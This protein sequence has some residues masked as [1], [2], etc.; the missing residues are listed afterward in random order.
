MIQQEPTES[1]SIQQLKDLRKL[2]GLTTK[3]AAEYAGVSEA[4][5]VKMESGSIKMPGK[6]WD[7]INVKTQSLPKKSIQKQVVDASNYELKDI[8]KNSKSWFNSEAKRLASV[9]AGK[10]TST[11]VSHPVPG[12]LYMYY[13]DAKHKDT[14]PYWDKFPLVFPFRMMP[15][16][17]IGINLHYLHY[18]QRILLLDALQEIAKSPRKTTSAKLTISYDILRTVAKGKHF[19]K[20]I[21]RYL[22]DHFKT[23][24]KKIHSDN[25]VMASLLPNEM[26]VGE[27]KEY[28]WKQ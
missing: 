16:G 4:A 17:F 13:Y 20:C 19:E 25:W 23:P 1:P 27:T 6:I 10:L 21:H 24:I 7:K 2:H 15:D 14:L 9:R 8:I 11:T 12:E 26:F 5:Y 3:Q 22:Y 28:I 18:K